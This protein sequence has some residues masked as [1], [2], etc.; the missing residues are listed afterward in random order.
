MSYVLI[1]LLTLGP[2]PIGDSNSMATSTDFPTREACLAAGKSVEQ[3][4]E[5]HRARSGFRAKT[6]TVL[7]LPKHVDGAAP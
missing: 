1:V 7:C 3:A 4:A 2:G 5:Q 6:V